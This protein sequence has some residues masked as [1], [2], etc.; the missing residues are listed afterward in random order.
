M[1]PGVQEIGV[2][3]RRRYAIAVILIAL[4]I[5]GVPAGVLWLVLDQPSPTQFP[6]PGPCDFMATQPGKYVLWHEYDTIFAG[7]TYSSNALPSG[8]TITCRDAVSGTN[9]SVRAD[10]GASM[11]TMNV[12]RESVAAVDIPAPG[13][14]L[15]RVEGATQP[16]L[17]SFGPAVLG[18]LLGAILGGLPVAFAL[19]IGGVALISNTLIRRSR[20]SRG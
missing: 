17:F 15:V 9:L 3:G 11:S 8:L 10:R 7:V 16:I 18:K 13:R 1:K 20:A 19:F 6:T 14:Y 12:R 5:F 2:P 4:A